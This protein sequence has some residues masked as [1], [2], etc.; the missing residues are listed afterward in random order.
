MYF[1][2]RHVLMFQLT[3]STFSP[4]APSSVALQLD[5]SFVCKNDIIKS[6]SFQNTLLAPHQMFGLISFP[7]PLAVFSCCKCPSQ[8]LSSI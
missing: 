1:Q 7:N 6:F 4:E 2:R 8:I 5:H 3:L